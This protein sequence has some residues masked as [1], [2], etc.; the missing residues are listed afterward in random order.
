MQH[1]YARNID[2]RYEFF[3]SRLDQFMV[4]L[5]WKSIDNPIETAVV[6]REDL[7]NRLFLTPQNFGTATNMGVEVDLI[8]YFNRIGIRA[9][10]TFT[11]SEITSSK[12]VQFRNQEGALSNRI[13]DQAR[14]L[15]GQSAHLGNFSLLYKNQESGTDLQLSM[16]YTGRRIAYISAFKDNDQWQR[17]F[18]ALDF[19]FDQ[20]I[21]SS[22]TAYAKVMNILNTPFELEIVAS[23]EIAAANEPHLQPDADRILSRSDLFHR[24]ILFGV[25]FNLNN[26]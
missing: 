15:Q 12:I 22:L 23:N 7:A 2:L 19:S 14:P 20:R 17:A 26:N 10:Y 4:G 24:T 13:E 11:N 9:N 3:P 5:F 21:T 8:R 16:V 1:A 6:R 18:T 25:R